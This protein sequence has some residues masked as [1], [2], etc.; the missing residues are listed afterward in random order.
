M[1]KFLLGCD[2]GTS[3]FRLRLLDVPGQL[4]IGE[5]LSEEGIASMHKS[6]QD[7]IRQNDTITKA[8]LFRQ[9]LK[10]QI[11]V[12]SGKYS[13]N[14]DNVTI[15]ISGMASS[16][17]GM[18]DI[19]YAMVPF[20]LD[21]S[22]AII[23]RLDLEDG[24]PHQIILISGVASQ[25]DVM[26]GEETQLI[27]LLALL[28]QSGNKPKEGVLIFP[29]THSKHI[30]IQNS[31]LVNFQTF[32]TGELFNIMCNYSILKDSVQIDEVN[33]FSDIDKDAFKSGLQES[34]SS[35]I[36]N[37][38]FTVRTNQLFDKLNK[39][40]NAFYLSGLLI[41]EEMNYLLKNEGFPLILCS[42][43]N[44]YEFYKLAIDEL[45]LSHRT[46]IVSFDLADQAAL[47]GQILIFQNYILN[48]RSR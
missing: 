12:L 27:G 17:I 14:L 15:L 24:F 19:P 9:Y 6:W 32:M 3:S 28:E 11:G 18:E 40:Q 13:V 20:A 35:G 37:G 7:C 25:K 23:K 1:D 36:L 30:Y 5:V 33:K 39:K 22:E 46:T 38:L 21:G 44:L 8:E 42:G 4:V 47:A 31:Q 41:G 34:K 10:K 26:R 45:D 29:G 48:Q 2:W 43:S 16:S